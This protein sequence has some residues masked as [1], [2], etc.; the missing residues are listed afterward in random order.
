MCGLGEDIV[1]EGIESWVKLSQEIN[2]RDERFEIT[3]KKSAPFNK[4]LS[5]I[6]KSNKTIVRYGGKDIDNLLS[7]Y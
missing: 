6:F 5:N 7:Q 1:S 4:D 2:L 3:D